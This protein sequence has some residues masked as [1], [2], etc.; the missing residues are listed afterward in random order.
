MKKQFIQFTSG[1]IP[2]SVLLLLAVALVAGQARANLPA[3]Y[4]VMSYEVSGSATRIVLTGRVLK[5]LQLSTGIREIAESM[6]ASLSA[7][8]KVL[9]PR[10]TNHRSPQPAAK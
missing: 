10:R 8:D 7:S 3:E 4:R 9:I 2:V 5:E 6:P 1:W